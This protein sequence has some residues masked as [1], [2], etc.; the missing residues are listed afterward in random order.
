MRLQLL[1]AAPLLTLR[2][3]PPALRSDRA[4]DCAIV[5]RGIWRAHIDMKANGQCLTSVALVEGSPT[6]ATARHRGLGVI[7]AH[8][9]RN[10]AQSGEGS[11]VPVE[12]GQLVLVGHPNDRITAGMREHHVQG[13]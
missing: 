13:M 2:I 5:L 11:V 6:A 1:V 9:S 12:P 10:A 3:L 8:N 4:L 7:H